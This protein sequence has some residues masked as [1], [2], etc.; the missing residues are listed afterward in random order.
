M[1]KNK[2]Y[3]QTIAFSG[4]CQA[5]T[6]IQN[7]AINGTYDEDGLIKTL[8]SILVTHPSSIDDVYKISDLKIGLNTVVN[9]FDDPKYAKDLFR[10]LV[11]VL[12]IE[13]KISRNSNLLQQIGN[14]VSQINK[15]NE[16]N[17]LE[18]G[19]NISDFASIYSDF[20][21]NIQPRIQIIG[22]PENLKQIDNQKR[23]RAL[24]LAA[25]RNTI[26]WKQS[27]GNRFTI[28]FRRSQIIKQAKEYLK[29]PTNL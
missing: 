3:N 29:S 22:K 4:I 17:Q 21:S 9:G 6:I 2:L 24:L 13:K 27:G 11:S 19:E 8:R 14:R 20:I 5:I 28:L 23:I 1:E 7:I 12:Q 26:L 25:I 18:I 15:K 16:L 10:Y